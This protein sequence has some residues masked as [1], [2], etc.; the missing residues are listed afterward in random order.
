MESLLLHHPPERGCRLAE[1]NRRIF[2]PV[3][4]QNNLDG[5]RAPGGLPLL[6]LKSLQAFEKGAQGGK[7]LV[8]INEQQF[9]G[10]FRGLDPHLNK[11]AAQGLEKCGPP[12][13]KNLLSLIGQGANGQ[14]GGMMNFFHSLCLCLNA[15]SP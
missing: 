7:G 2:F 8:I 10:A 1:I 12:L 11:E 4:M 14:Q 5:N 3:Q 15:F 13:V 6:F 9:R